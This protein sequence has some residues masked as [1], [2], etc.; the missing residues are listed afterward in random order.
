MELH[1]TLCLDSIGKIEAFN[2]V[3]TFESLGHLRLESL[4]NMQ[5]FLFLKE[6]QIYLSFQP[7]TK[8]KIYD[9]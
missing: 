9:F 4:H 1:Q 5:T 2:K 7:E 8:L 3:R 6:N